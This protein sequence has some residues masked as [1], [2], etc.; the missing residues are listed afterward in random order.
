MRHNQRIMRRLLFLMCIIASFCM[1][2]ILASAD[3]L[4][5]DDEM[6]DVEINEYNFPDYTFREEVC[7]KFD[8]NEDGIL[9]VPE[10]Q[11]VKKIY[12]GDSSIESIIG[13]RQFVALEQLTIDHGFGQYKDKITEIDVSGLKN[14]RVLECDFMPNL[15]SLNVNECISLVRISCC[16]TG[17]KE[18]EVRNL[19]WLSE[20]HCSNR[21]HKD[22]WHLDDYEYYR[23]NTPTPL[24]RLTISNCPYLYTVD[25][26]GNELTELDV[27]DC[28]HLGYLDCSNNNLTE[29]DVRN[30]K[31]LYHLNCSQNKIKELDISHLTNLDEVDCSRN[32]LTELIAKNATVRGKLDCRE[33]NLD[34]VDFS[35]TGV[36]KSNCFFDK[37]VKVDH[38]TWLPKYIFIALGIIVIAVL[39][40]LKVK[41][42]KKLKK[43][44]SNFDMPE[45]YKKEQ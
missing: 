30:C 32:R 15:C 37:G 45:W 40:I 13:I 26:S 27:S 7:R 31:G 24:E 6:H 9:S 25:C 14:L 18:L 1:S 2:I 4:Q 21:D 8:A 28:E 41:K 19:P 11:N 17:L 39:I 29:L 22:G 5:A 38:G 20:L 43:L 35:T 34:E 36:T 23:D 16:G 3:S 12:I 42:N 33:N 44:A 10:I